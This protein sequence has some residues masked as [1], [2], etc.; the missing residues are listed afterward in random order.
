[1]DDAPAAPRRTNRRLSARRACRLNV[2]YRVDS[3]W[4]P[5]TAMD[6]SVTGC[7]LRVGE[8]LPRGGQVKVA[9]ESLLGNGTTSLEV[10]V[11]GTVMWSRREGL[12]FQSGIQFLEAPNGLQ[13]ILTALS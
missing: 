12:S 5:A 1:M 11:E 9:F 7:R 10:E 8:D 3:N 6:L 2:R 4:H 13:D